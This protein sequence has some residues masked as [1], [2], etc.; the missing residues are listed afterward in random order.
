MHSMR[1]VADKLVE[2]IDRLAQRPRSLFGLGV[3]LITLTGLI[4]HL[5]GPYIAISPLYAVPVGVGAWY[6]G[7]AAGEG[8]AGL[9]VAMGLLADA[10]S[11]ANAGLVVIFW[12][13]AARALILG[14]IAWLVARMRAAFVA[15]NEAG[16]AAHRIAEQLRAADSVKNTFLSAVSHELRTPLAA[17]LGS[18]RTLEDLQAVLEETDRTA[19]AAAISRNAWRL[20]RLV[21]DLLDVDRISRGATA[22]DRTEVDLAKLVAGVIEGMDIPRGRRVHVTAESLIGQVDAAKVERVV[23][24]LIANALKYAPADAPIHVRVTSVDGE[25]ALLVED[26]G[27]GVAR[28]DREAIFEPFNR[29]GVS[30]DIPG[31]GMGLSLVR[32]FAE[33]HGGAAWV[34]DRPGGGA[35]FV[36]TLPR[37]P[38]ASRLAVTVA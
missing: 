7:L 4:D 33:M 36:V 1:R 29:A 13:A 11:F 23:E 17:I 15:A 10:A 25:L 26:G 38:A 16:E 21:S 6:L 35:R 9:A 19:L 24:N 20:D 3:F 37:D 34:E 5:T 8:L 12:N 28:E 31:V 27:L 18:A 32:A 22:L 2:A 14:F 30:G